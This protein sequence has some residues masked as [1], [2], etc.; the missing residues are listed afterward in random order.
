MTVL[1]DD[2]KTKIETFPGSYRFLYGPK[3]TLNS[4]YLF[5]GLNPGGSADDE[6]DLSLSGNAFIEEK[7]AGTKINA[8]QNQVQALFRKMAAHLHVADWITFMS[9]DWLVSNY[10]FYRSRRWPDMAAKKGHIENCKE[11]WRSQFARVPPKIVICN[12][13]DTYAEMKGLLKEQGW[14]LDSER[15]ADRAWDGPHTAIMTKEA[16]RCLMVGFAHLSTFKVVNRAENK[17]AM[18]TV[19]ARIAEHWVPR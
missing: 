13:Y 1:L 9:Y 17:A 16:S 14:V 10:V 8:L 7:W 12:G 15:L 11:I 3:S 18:A 5:V 19:Y 2:I 6:S 4:P